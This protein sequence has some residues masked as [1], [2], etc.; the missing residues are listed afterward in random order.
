MLSG[1]IT[2]KQYDVSVKAYEDNNDE[3]GAFEKATK[4]VINKESV[5]VYFE[6][7]S[8]FDDWWEDFTD[9]TVIYGFNLSSEDNPTGDDE[10]TEIGLIME[11]VHDSLQAQIYNFN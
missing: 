1:V 8:V 10:P 5:T 4:V 11:S 9:A 3:Y 2:K 6:N 7:K